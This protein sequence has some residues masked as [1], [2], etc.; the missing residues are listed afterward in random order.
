MSF[1]KILLF[2]WVALHDF[3]DMVENAIC[4]YNKNPVLS[5]LCID[6]SSRNCVLIVRNTSTHAYNASDGWASSVFDTTSFLDISATSAMPCT[7]SNSKSIEST[8]PQT[9]IY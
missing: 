1:S 4:M 7:I 3:D 9:C 6:I 8:V 5:N 2:P